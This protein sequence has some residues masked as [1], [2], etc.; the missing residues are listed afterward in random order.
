M[1]TASERVKKF[2]QTKDIGY[3]FTSKDIHKALG[4]NTSYG[5]ITG[6][7]N[8]YTKQGSIKVFGKEGN[9]F[10]YETVKKSCDEPSNSLNKEF[11][12]FMLSTFQKHI[13]EVDIRNGLHSYTNKELLNE[14]LKRIKDE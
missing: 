3:K 7:L 12:D 10:I 13:P 1:K 4:I 9:T 2:I 5:G 6:A 14:L 8:R 11:I